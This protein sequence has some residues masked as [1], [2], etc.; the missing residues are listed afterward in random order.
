MRLQLQA[1]QLWKGVELE[2]A[3]STAPLAAHPRHHRL[4]V[5]ATRPTALTTATLVTTN[6]SAN[7]FFLPTHKIFAATGTL[8]QEQTS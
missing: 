8:S 6:F 2:R 1:K 5:S 3:G 7:G 4:A